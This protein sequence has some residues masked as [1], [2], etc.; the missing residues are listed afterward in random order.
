MRAACSTGQAFTEGFATLAHGMCAP[1]GC[2]VLS[3][4]KDAQ[5]PRWAPGTTS[6]KHEA[7][8]GPTG[9]AGATE[10]QQET[11]WGS[12]ESPGAAPRRTHTQQAEA[13][14]R[15]RRRS[16]RVRGA[17]SSLGDVHVHQRHRFTWRMAEVNCEHCSLCHGRE[18]EG[19]RKGQQIPIAPVRVCLQ[20]ARVV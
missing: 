19:H 4:E 13:S 11:L 9:N 15:R 2:L 17:Q 20:T 7:Q 8:Q 14:A 1:W 5:Q 10:E 16:R 18:A 3:T 12:G 6:P